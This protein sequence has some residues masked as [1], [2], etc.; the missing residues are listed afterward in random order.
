MESELIQNYYFATYAKAG[1]EILTKKKN[2]TARFD[3]VIFYDKTYYRAH[4]Y[5]STYDKL[6]EDDCEELI[7]YAK[8]DEDDENDYEGCIELK[9]GEWIEDIHDCKLICAH[10][11]TGKEVDAYEYLGKLGYEIDWSESGC[12]KFASWVDEEDLP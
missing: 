12:I 9:K 11:K 4:L 2:K 7:S 6:D 3:D 5:S 1:V 8:D 10:M